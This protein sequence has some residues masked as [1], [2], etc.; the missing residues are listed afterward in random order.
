MRFYHNEELRSLT[1]HVHEAVD[2]MNHLSDLAQKIPMLEYGQE[3]V[4]KRTQS[5]RIL[6]LS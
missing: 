5:S 6:Q 4:R 3:A 2:K 1:E